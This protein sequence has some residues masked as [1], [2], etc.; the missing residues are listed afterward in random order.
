MGAVVEEMVEVGD[1]GWVE[2]LV[3]VGFVTVLMLV[4]WVE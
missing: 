4:M 1:T 3:K 2:L